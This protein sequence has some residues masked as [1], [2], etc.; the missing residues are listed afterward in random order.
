M[1]TR[2]GQSTMQVFTEQ[3]ESCRWI[4]TMDA[5]AAPRLGEKGEV[6]QWD[7][8]LDFICD[9]LVHI[10]ALRPV[11]RHCATDATAHVLCH[12]AFHEHN[13][14]LDPYSDP[15]LPIWCRCIA[16]FGY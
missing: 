9:E 3:A 13:M 8:V 11:C 16:M 7:E 15:C 12:L 2:E 1:S 14:M 5:A 6:L 10:Q 4:C